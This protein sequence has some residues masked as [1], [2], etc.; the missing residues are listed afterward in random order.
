MRARDEQAFADL[1]GQYQAQLLAWIQH[2]TLNQDLSEEVAQDLWLY[3]WQRPHVVDLSRGSFGAWLKVVARRRAVDC[4][5]SVHAS[6]RRDRAYGLRHIHET[7]PN[8]EQRASLTW[9]RPHLKAALEQLSHH[10][11]TAIELLHFAE[12]THVEAAKV[13][14]VPVATGKTR[15]RDGLLKLQALMQSATGDG[16]GL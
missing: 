2:V 10:Q 12:L 14:G 6:R 16:A 8:P 4:V 15:Y 13:L 1:R 9:H 11:R 5:R 7:E 3:L